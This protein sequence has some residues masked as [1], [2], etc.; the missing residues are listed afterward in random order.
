MDGKFLQ[1]GTRTP[2]RMHSLN[3]NLETTISKL[4]KLSKLSQKASMNHV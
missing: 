4:S 2:N 1:K 3:C